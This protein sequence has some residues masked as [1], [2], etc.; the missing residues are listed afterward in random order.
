[1]TDTPAA[2]E[3]GH[4]HERCRRQALDAAVALCRKNGARLTPLRRKV[5]YAVWQSHEPIGAYEICAVL[6]G[7]GDGILPP[8]VYRALG[9][10]EKQGLI[11]RLSTLNA[12]IGCNQP[13]EHRAGRY[14]ICSDCGRVAELPAGDLMD[15]VS[16]EAAGFHF[17]AQAVHLE[18]LGRC[19]ACAGT[20]GKA[21]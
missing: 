11:H 8:T 16:S 10:L 7:K 20:S 5:L 9:F 6:N 2:F 14:L 15:R 4:D 21:A 1:M 3:R 13:G 18:A 12:Y 17:E 19:L